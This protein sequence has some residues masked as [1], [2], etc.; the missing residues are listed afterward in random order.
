MGKV[1]RALPT[2]VTD[3]L[4][5]DA[6]FGRY[7]E[8]LN[9]PL[10]TPLHGVADEGSYYILTNPTPGTGIATLAAP[11][12]YVVTS[13]YVLV[14]NNDVPTG[15]RV[16][17]H[18]IKLIT[19]SAGTGG[20]SLHYNIV[21]DNIARYTSG[22]GLATI[23]A[24]PVNVNM[25]SSNTSI[26]QCYAGPLVAAAAGTSAR[27]LGGGIFKTGIPIVGDTYIANFGAESFNVGSAVATIN[28]VVFQHPPVIIGPQS[29]L[30]FYL[31]LPSQSGA[32]SY[33]IEAGW[34]ER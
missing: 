29:C 33:E 30:L 24:L 20:A 1:G 6:R 25:D 16:Y 31:W 14:K 13:P 23:P 21:I 15:K 19:T 2:P 4:S 27:L 18:Y 3:G 28:S 7:G 22:S 5:T 8:N 32:T 26:T 10:L 11:T 12:A 9:I 17:F 34:W